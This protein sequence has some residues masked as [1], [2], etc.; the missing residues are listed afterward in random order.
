MALSLALLATACWSPPERVGPRLRLHGG[1]Y[2]AT[3]T[4]DEQLLETGVELQLREL[5]S[6]RL[7]PAVGIVLIQGDA[8]FLSTSLRRDFWFT[9]SFGLLVASGFGYFGDGYQLELGGDFEFRST[10]ELAHRF[11]NG[12]LIGY[13]VAHVSNGGLFDDNPGANSVLLSVTIPLSRSER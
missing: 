3:E 10:A 9:P 12:V 8:F 5:T 11:S 4:R 6:W 13:G 2:N 7:V 1:V